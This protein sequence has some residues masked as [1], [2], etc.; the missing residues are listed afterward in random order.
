[1]VFWYIFPLLLQNSRL[2]EENLLLFEQACL[3]KA[4][5]NIVTQA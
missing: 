5:L 2:E 4:V 1:M 3:F